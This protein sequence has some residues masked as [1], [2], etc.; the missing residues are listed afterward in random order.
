MLSGAVDLSRGALTICGYID[1]GV[2]PKYAGT[3]TG[4]NV[5]KERGQ[6]LDGSAEPSPG[7]II[8]Y[9]RAKTDLTDRRI[10]PAI[11]SSSNYV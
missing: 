8:F 7:M 1:A 4:V 10:T 6:W 11:G 9:D 2:I 5:F 3:S